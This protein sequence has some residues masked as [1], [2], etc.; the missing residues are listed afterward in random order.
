MVFESRLLRRIF[1]PKRDYPHEVEWTPF[2]THYSSENLVALVFNPE[3][4]GT[5]AR[6]SDHYTTEAVEL[7]IIGLKSFWAGEYDN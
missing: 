2:Q 7:D 3:T 6:N 5:V 4:S 1:G